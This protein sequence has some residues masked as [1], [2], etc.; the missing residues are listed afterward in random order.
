MLSDQ[1]D[2]DVADDQGDH[3]DRGSAVPRW[4][5]PTL[6]AILERMPRSSMTLESDPQWR[7]PLHKY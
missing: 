3:G 2:A 6:V 1:T 5:E 7:L 4:T